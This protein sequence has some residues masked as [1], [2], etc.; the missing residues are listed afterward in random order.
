MNSCSSA[1]VSSSEVAHLFLVLQCRIAGVRGSRM[2]RVDEIPARPR[3]EGRK[4]CATDAN[5]RDENDAREKRCRRSRHHPTRS[6]AFDCRAGRRR[7][8][9]QRARMTITKFQLPEGPF[10]APQ[11]FSS[12]AFHG[13]DPCRRFWRA[14]RC[15][16]TIPTVRSSLSSRSKT[17]PL[18]TG[19]AIDSGHSR[20]MNTGYHCGGARSFRCGRT[21]SWFEPQSKLAIASLIFTGIR[22]RK[23][24]PWAPPE[25]CDGRDVH[26]PSTFMNREN[27][28]VAEV[29]R[30]PTVELSAHRTI[31]DQN[32]ARPPRV[33]RPYQPV[34]ATL[35]RAGPR[36]YAGRSPTFARE[37]SCPSR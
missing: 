12:K 2:L 7:R 6:G 9:C 21:H 11:K 36:P 18:F 22:S 4:P 30:G 1:A 32:G 37:V 28:R 17:L 13:G 23:A 15:T 16:T 20:T 29:H 3:V 27:H 26:R 5:S 19:R 34:I 10:T 31:R 8:R 35:Y 33:S 24:K 14:A 25:R